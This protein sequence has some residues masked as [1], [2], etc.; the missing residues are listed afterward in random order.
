MHLKFVDP[1]VRQWVRDENLSL[2][3]AVPL[4]VMVEP[5][6]GEPEVPPLLGALAELDREIFAILEQ[7]L[8]P[9][10][11]DIPLGVQARAAGYLT[12]CGLGPIRRWPY[13]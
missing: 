12:A 3:D 5:P 7:D 8:Y 1:I 13:K 2:A 4:G 6:Y 10:A 9:V 11:P